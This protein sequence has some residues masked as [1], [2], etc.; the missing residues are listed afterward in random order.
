MASSGQVLIE[1]SSSEYDDEED[2]ESESDRAG[3]SMEDIDEV[4]PH[5]ADILTGELS[6]SIAFALPAVRVEEVKRPFQESTHKLQ[7]LHKSEQASIGDNT[8][9][10]NIAIDLEGQK[11]QCSSK[12]TIRKET[13]KDLQSLK[14]SKRSQRKKEQTEQ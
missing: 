7:E 11:L 12:R 13:K 2:E 4:E 5:T 1:P 14:S 8:S 9:L 10:T 6:G 3:E